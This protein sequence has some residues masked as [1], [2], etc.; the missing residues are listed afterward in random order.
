YPAQAPA[1]T[2]R[3]ATGIISGEA[4]SSGGLDVNIRGMQGQGRVPVTVDGAINGTTVYRG[5]QGTSNRSFVDPDFISHIAI[6]KGPSMGNA[7]AGGIGGSVSMK[8]LGVDDIVPE[9]DVMGIRLMASLS[10][11]NTTPNSNMT[12]N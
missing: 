7:I 6:E 4:R 12:R 8:T 5:Y 11:N 1:D 3:G 10:G 9:G 2:L